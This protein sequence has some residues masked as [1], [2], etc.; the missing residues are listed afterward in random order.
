MAFRGNHLR[1]VDIADDVA[2][3]RFDYRFLAGA[4]GKETGVGVF[5]VDYRLGAAK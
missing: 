1:L 5:D 4:A 2:D 3:G